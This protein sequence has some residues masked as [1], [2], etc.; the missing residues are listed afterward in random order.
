MRDLFFVF[1]SAVFI[2]YSCETTDNKTDKLPNNKTSV[3]LPKNETKDAH[4]FSN[5]QEVHT[6]HLHLDLDINFDTKIINGIARHKISKHSTDSIIFD[7]KELEIF[8]VT[9]GKE[10]ENDVEFKLGEKNPL[11]GQSLT[12]F[13]TPETEFVN[14]YYQTTDECEA[15]D[16]LPA[17][18]TSGKKEPFLYT[19]GQAILTRSWIPLQDSPAIRITYSADV[20]TN[21]DVLVL[22]SAS[23][24]TQQN[25]ERFYH[26]EMNQRIPSYLIALAAGD[27]IYT[28]INN[29]CGI[30]SEKELA[31]DCAYEFADLPKMIDAASNLY[32]PYLWDKY[33]II[34]LPYSFPFGGM[35]NPRL[36]FAN[37]TLLTGD[38]SS[39][40]VIAH[41]LAH[42]WSG[43]LVTN[44]TWNDFWLNEGFT[45]YFENRIME[46]IYG[47]ETA[48][49]L[50]TIEYQ[51]LMASIEEIE[52]SNYP[53]DS[54]LKLALN[55]RNPD[56]GMTD[57]AYVKGSLF[58]RT[59]ENEIGRDKLDA[60][61]KQ[62]FIDHAFE[63][64]TT[65]DFLKDL[66]EKLL[67]PTKSTFNY[68]EWIYKKGIPKNHVKLHSDRLENMVLIAQKINQGEDVFSN[69]F[70][71]IKRKDRITQEWL[72]FI[73]NLDDNLSIDRMKEIDNHFHFSTEANAIIKSDW[74][75]L[76]A[77]TKYR[78]IYPLMSN[79]LQ[80]IGRRW[81]VEGIYANLKNTNDD[82]E[83]NFAKETFEKAKVNY[84]YVTRSTIQKILYEQSN[85]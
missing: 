37:P 36:T 81:L 7:T 4:S 83:F 34:V 19:Q 20:K 25:K 74:F 21:R 64:I 22:M 73:R 40:T 65:E 12:V 85:S 18:L 38:R 8:K 17:E 50:T 57:I 48:N 11:L 42:S 15:L 30:Y 27:L 26:F 46:E 56:E 1:I 80:K 76:S 29:I 61:L 31:K 5:T 58:I 82:F 51:D 72:T 45:V 69:D 77:K 60:F 47:K 75:K 9:I 13:I 49:I 6:E 44:A 2:F 59:L 14:I 39:T 63:S 71:G 28:P 35:E 24:P 41:E 79:Y 23:N 78:E 43:N 70:N 3:P 10:D 33:D 68:E 62:Y 67:I 55:E 32:G 84:H 66:N 54:K 16:W 53:E 52:K